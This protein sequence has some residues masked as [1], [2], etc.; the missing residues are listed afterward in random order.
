MKQCDIAGTTRD[1]DLLKAARSWN[2]AVYGSWC[3]LLALVRVP[4]G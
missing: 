2:H 3:N 1:A 4:K